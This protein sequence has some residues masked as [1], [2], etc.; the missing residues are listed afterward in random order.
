MSSIKV[1]SI[2][3]NTTIQL[4]GEFIFDINAEF[5][6]AYKENKRSER[7]TVDLSQTNY[8]DSS[9]LGMLLQLREF[10]G[11]DKAVPDQLIAS[12][13]RICV[14]NNLKDSAKPIS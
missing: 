1:S 4:T 11:G 9:G 6:R 12:P 2:G 14:H 13:N 3:N 7:Y 5:R 8:M 10:A